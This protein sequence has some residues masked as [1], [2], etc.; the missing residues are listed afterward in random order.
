MFSSE[1]EFAPELPVGNISFIFNLFPLKIVVVFLGSSYPALWLFL[2]II[3][4]W[5]NLVFL[6]FL[7][8]FIS[9][10]FCIIDFYCILSFYI[11]LIF[12][13]ILFH[14]IFL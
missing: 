9:L 5:L 8:L 12:K 4:F 14:C 10:Y 2:Y 11:I 13:N 1:G 6:S 3:L 7:I